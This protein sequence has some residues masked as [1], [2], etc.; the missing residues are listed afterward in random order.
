MLVKQIRFWDLCSKSKASP[1]I[2]SDIQLKPCVLSWGIYW[3]KWEKLRLNL[4]FKFLLDLKK[5]IFYN[6]QLIKIH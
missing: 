3:N 5:G 6:I 1:F 4:T 2:Y